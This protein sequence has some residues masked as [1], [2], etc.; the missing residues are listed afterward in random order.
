ML[1]DSA[2]VVGATDIADFSGLV[3]LVLLGRGVSRSSLLVLMGLGVMGGAVTLAGAAK[4]V[5][6]EGRCRVGPFAGSVG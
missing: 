6:T 1:M 4:R 2:G 5:S 3:I